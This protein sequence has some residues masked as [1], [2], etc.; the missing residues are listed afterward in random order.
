MP[1]RQNRSSLGLSWSTAAE[2]EARVIH[3]MI[4]YATEKLDR[5]Y[6]LYP[7]LEEI[8]AQEGWTNG[9]TYGDTC[10]SHLG[11]RPAALWRRCQE[12]GSLQ[13]IHEAS[14]LTF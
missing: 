14:L 9:F 6:K 10:W 12:A 8:A 5:R 2:L 4:R 7:T 1:R 3:V 11:E 13:P